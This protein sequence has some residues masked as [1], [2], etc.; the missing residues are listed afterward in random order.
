MVTAPIALMLLAGGVPPRTAVAPGT[1]QVSVCPEPCTGQGVGKPAVVGTLVLTATDIN[2]QRTVVTE[3]LS[4]QTDFILY[5]DLKPNACFVLETRSE[6]TP[7]LAGLRR[8][9]LTR[10]TEA[11]GVV[12][13]TL[14]RS[15]DASDVAAAVVR[16]DR[17]LAGPKEEAQIRASS[18]YRRSFLSGKRTGP[19]DVNVCIRA[20]QAELER[21]GTNEVKK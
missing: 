17:L 1:Y 11:G 3:F 20:A 12:T 2:L 5:P 21:R 10:W 6:D 15:P 4:D 16:G 13:M 19:P 7:L 18:E 9:G 14:Y 8:V